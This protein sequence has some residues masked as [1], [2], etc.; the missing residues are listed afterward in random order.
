PTV[1]RLM[2][3]LADSGG[4]DT[5]CASQLSSELAEQRSRGV[6][7]SLINLGRTA[8]SFKGDPAF[9]STAAAPDS[10]SL[11]RAVAEIYQR[12]IGS[13]KTQTGAISRQVTVE[14]DPY[15]K[16]AFLVVA[17]DGPLPGLQIVPPNPGAEAIELD[18]H[19]GGSTTGLDGVTRGYRIVRLQNP[20]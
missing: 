7:V 8:G 15:V 12:F 4:F 3:F 6:M 11:V 2:L 5:N 1:P 13:K 18:Y 17:A 20:N 16:E 19:G 14:V 9:D 10:M